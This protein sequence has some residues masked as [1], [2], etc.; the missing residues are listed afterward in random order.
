MV[1]CPGMSS[2]P[3]AMAQGLN[4]T[5]GAMVAGLRAT[6]SGWRLAVDDVWHEAE[7][8]VLTIPAPQARDLLGGDHAFH[9]ALADISYDPC[10]ALMAGLDKEAPQPFASAIGQGASAWIAHD[11]GKPA[12]QEQPLATWVMQ[13]DAKFSAQ[14]I[15]RGFDELARMMA[16][17][18]LEKL[19]ADADAL[20]H[21]VAHRWLYSRTARALGQSFLADDGA[22][23]LVGGDW[24]LGPDV[25]HGWASGRAMAAHILSRR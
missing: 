13:A 3:K 9:D 2:I 19:G 25:Q 20:Q 8:V 22:R 11:G 21:A 5:Q 10:I 23:L 17:I 18:L 16:P 7:T 12:R 6:T 24:A 15:D 14:H 4:V 1:G